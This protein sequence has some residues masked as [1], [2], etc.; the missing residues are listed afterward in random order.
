MS[1]ASGQHSSFCDSPQRPC[2]SLP[3]VL[4]L[5]VSGDTIHFDGTNTDNKPYSCEPSTSQH[6]GTPT[7][8]NISLSLIG[9]G[10]LVFFH[11]P[12][13]IFFTGIRAQVVL[14]QLNFF[15]TPL[16]FSNCS[17]FIEKSFFGSSANV[18]EKSSDKAEGVLK[19]D[20]TPNLS[21][22]D[23]VF[24]E[25]AEVR[26]SGG[27][28]MRL[29]NDRFHGNAGAA[30]SITPSPGGT[31]SVENCAFVDNWGGLRVLGMKNAS[32]D[33]KN[34]QFVGNT[35]DS[36]LVLELL[37]FSL[38]FL[39]NVTI[40]NNTLQ[41]DSYRE[42]A[43]VY[44][45]C[46]L[47]RNNSVFID[48]STFQRNTN[49]KMGAGAIFIDNSA[50]LMTTQGCKSVY[51]TSVDAYPRFSYT[52]QIVFKDAAFEENVGR[53]TGAVVA[54]NGL[55]IFTN[56]TFVNNL[57]QH[58]AGHVSVAGGTGGLEIYNCTFR[59]TQRVARTIL[60]QNFSTSSFLYTN[61]PG[62]LVV[63][64][65]WMEF[66][67]LGSP[68]LVEI[69]NGGHVLIDNSSS[70]VCPVGSEIFVDNYSHL[71]E[72][73]SAT[74]A[75]TS[76]GL[77]VKVY[78]VYCSSCAPGYYSLRK[79]LTKGTTAQRGFQCLP[80][81]FG[82]NCSGNIASQPHFWGAL[83][84][85]DPPTLKF[86]VCP[87][88]YCAPPQNAAPSVYNGCQGN[89]S[90]ILCGACA[91]GYSETLFSSDCRRDADCND[92]WFWPAA[93]LYAVVAALFFVTR[94]PVVPYLMSQIFWFRPATK[95]REGSDDVNGENSEGTLKSEN[96]DRLTSD[97]GC[98]KV[99]CYFYQVVGLLLVATTAA[100]SIR[101]HF[102]V[103]LLG[104]F[105]FKI[106]AS[107]E[108]FG[109]PFPGITVPLKELFSIFEVFSVVLCIFLLYGARQI[110]AQVRGL[111]H[112]PLAPYL[113]AA[114]EVIILGYASL[115]T[116]AFKL[117]TMQRLA[118]AND[119][120][121]FFDGNIMFFQWWQ[122][123][124][125][126]CVAVYVVPF[127][128]VLFWGAIWLNDNRIAAREFLIACVVPLPV[129]IYWTLWKRRLASGKHRRIQQMEERIAV[130]D[131]LH[132]P[133]RIPKYGEKGALYWESVLIGRRL[134]LINLF[135]FI[136]VASL[137]LLLSTIVCL[138]YAVHHL[139]CN[140]YK[141]RKVN[142]METVSLLTLVILGMMNTV[143]AT[144]LTGGIR[145]WGPLNSYLDTLEW[146]Q[147]CILALLP[148]ALTIAVILA[149]LSQ[150]VRVGVV[151]CTF[152]HQAFVQVKLQRSPSVISD[153]SKTQDAVRDSLF[154]D[155]ELIDDR[156]DPQSACQMDLASFSRSNGDRNDLSDAEK[157]I[158]RFGNS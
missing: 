43:S 25:N 151:T 111:R 34:T 79:G 30:V 149:I 52:N 90:G 106:R 13:G 56:C 72:V 137:R 155:K 22:T 135:A 85:L 88:G 57:A 67:P 94:P 64:G 80:C 11:C 74:S 138:F 29:I 139:L 107:T 119:L 95:K 59:Q 2:K 128:G 21:I 104:V 87:L 91:H 142:T 133:Y 26:I 100:H 58:R 130:M 126:A 156:S 129:L 27:D 73:S 154:G 123:G 31:V 120:H 152:L 84:K 103:A 105:N 76:C 98:L 116:S 62:T 153:S 146:I 82:G 69:V 10:S 150:V 71:I 143:H 86:Y 75:D 46:G 141:D 140:P 112:P 96:A 61:S 1:R 77:D 33:M 5:V 93:I 6:P 78:S 101:A 60:G 37:A 122:I 24:F 127:V 118:P 117:L 144:L 32:L 20:Y 63:K 38:A 66:H 17:V 125:F 45:R 102:L 19:F 99:I 3:Q 4:R 40:Q 83:E 50:D 81:P 23:S 145:L 132:G 28:T 147:A 157:N 70:L 131:V 136:Q 16:S 65:T 39:Q 89:R 9:Q 148:L 113:A 97:T 121:L 42:A 54:S 124:L 110:W 92:F 55:V 114:T 49:L 8:I 47:Q 41:T 134:L 7:S 158:T 14:S 18:Y 44:I 48:G 51:N 53:Y 68:T 15:S 109:C 12:A 108:G 35:G 115:A 36:A